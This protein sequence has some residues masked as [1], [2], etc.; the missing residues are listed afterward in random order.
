VSRLAE[1]YAKLERERKV[2][3]DGTPAGISYTAIIW[4]LKQGRISEFE[5]LR[6]LRDIV[7][8][9]LATGVSAYQGLCGPEIP[10]ATLNVH[11]GRQLVALLNGILDVQEKLRK[12]QKECSCPTEPKPEESEPGSPSTD[13]P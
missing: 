10:S 3:E 2:E 7:F 5:V 12:E 4:A 1:I 6:D 11:E 13:T 9:E 8:A